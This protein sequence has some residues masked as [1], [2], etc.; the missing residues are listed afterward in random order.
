MT[1]TIKTNPY[2]VGCCCGN[3]ACHKFYLD[4]T[5]KKSWFRYV[6]KWDRMKINNILDAEGI[7]HAML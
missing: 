5:P 1:R 4:C 6:R 3:K 2:E 7:K